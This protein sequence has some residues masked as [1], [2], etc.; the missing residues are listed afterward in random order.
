MLDAATTS[1][2]RAILEEVCEHIS[3]SE[4][5]VRAHIASKMLEAASRGETTRERLTQVAI[6][7][8]RQAPSM[9]R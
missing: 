1:L 6:E 3:Q 2:L 7:A 5:G 8:L 4:T 9:W